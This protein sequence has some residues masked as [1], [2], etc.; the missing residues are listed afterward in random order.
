MTIAK[1]SRSERNRTIIPFG[2]I[3]ILQ[4]SRLLSKIKRFLIPRLVFLIINFG[5]PIPP[6][7]HRSLSVKGLPT[8]AST[9]R[10][11]SLLLYDT[12]TSIT[13]F[14]LQI[15]SY[16]H[17]HLHLKI[18]IRAYRRLVVLMVILGEPLQLI[19]SQHTGYRRMKH[20]Y[21][22]S[23]FQGESCCCISKNR[24]RSY[25]FPRPHNWHPSILFYQNQVFL[26]R[27]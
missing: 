7:A 1:V 8:S 16:C 23:C 15:L 4:V 20:V 5:E 17:L 3:S 6:I 22:S 25:L 10:V 27:N 12:F 19:S 24:L 18:Q 14:V 2:R 26:F 13:I 21:N 9:F 11:I